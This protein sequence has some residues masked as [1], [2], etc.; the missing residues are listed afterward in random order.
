MDI[1]ANIGDRISRLFLPG[2][3]RERYIYC[4]RT[5]DFPYLELTRAHRMLYLFLRFRCV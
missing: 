2:R 4:L 1:V 3:E 5:V